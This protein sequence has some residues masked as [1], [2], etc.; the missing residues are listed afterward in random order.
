MRPVLSVVIPTYN[1]PRRLA[2]LLADLDRDLP[3]WAEIIV[4]D[5]SEI[6]MCGTQKNVRYIRRKKANLPAARN[7]GIAA[8]RGD[9]ILFLDD[10]VVPMPKLLETHRQL[11]ESIPD[12]DCIAGRIN[13]A[14]NRGQR[15]LAAIIDY[16]TMTCLFDFGGDLAQDVDSPCG[17][18]MSF[19]RTALQNSWFDPA[20]IGNA[21]FEEVDLALRLRARGKQ[22]R[23]CPE[24][25]VDHA[26]DTE[27]G[28]RSLKESTRFYQHHFRNTALCFVKNSSLKYIKTF[29]RKQRNDC[30]FYSR[31]PDKSGR[32]NKRF[33]VACICG[34]T[35]GFCI[36]LW[37]RV[38][39]P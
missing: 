28:C 15:Q 3:A 14:N 17:A 9:I 20:Y 31:I 18:H 27:G 6:A 29:L 26:L 16:T 7:C 30:E 23:F 38:F 2:R 1:R 13:D 21:H 10:D 39:G 5:Q 35:Q 37:R 36:G 8:A 24:A 34:V 12:V 33:V 32:H 11:H 4:V 25:M 22:I 19:K